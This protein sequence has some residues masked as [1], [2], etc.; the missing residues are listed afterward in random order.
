MDFSEMEK[1]ELFLTVERALKAKGVYD[2]RET[3]RQTAARIR[4]EDPD[5]AGML[6][7]AE[8]RWDELQN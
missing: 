7:R 3:W 6:I 4:D 8:E 5:L 1:D 2:V